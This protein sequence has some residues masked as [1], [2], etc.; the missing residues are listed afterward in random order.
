MLNSC[1]HAGTRVGKAEKGLCV[2]IL[3]WPEQHIDCTKCDG[4]ARVMVDCSN[5]CA[6]L[7]TAGQSIALV[8][9]VLLYCSFL[10][11]KNNGESVK[12]FC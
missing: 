12:A 10:M 9:F 1:V 5:R 6:Q 4:A 3:E 8:L 7:L 11:K 2:H